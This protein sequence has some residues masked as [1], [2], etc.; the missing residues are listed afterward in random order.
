MVKN[1]KI[2]KDKREKLWKEIESSI[3][4]VAT[5]KD[6]KFCLSGRWKK[7]LKIEKGY[8][9]YK[10]DGSW[11]RKNLCCYFGHGG[12]G[13]VHEFIPMDEL[14]ISTHHYD[15]GPYDLQKCNCKTRTK[16]QKVSSEYFKSTTLHEMTECE[17]MKKGKSF[18]EA[19]NLAVE[20]EKEAGFLAD[21]YSDL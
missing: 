5:K 19:H 3:Q 15:D 7:F 1:I 13:F 10:V 2:P 12:H 17:Y 21:P 16:N 6:K 14:W 8:R 4:K 11:I 20:A 18:W 9:I